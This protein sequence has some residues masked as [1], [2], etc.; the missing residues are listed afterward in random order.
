[1]LPPWKVPAEHLGAYFQPPVPDDEDVDEELEPSEP[2]LDPASGP[3]PEPADSSFRR[4]RS[5]YASAV[6]YADEAVVWLLDELRD[7][8][9]AEETL[10]VVTTDH[11]QALGEHGIIGPYRPW[12][13]DE[14]IH[15]PLTLRLP[16]AAEGGRRI[17]ALAQSTD[18]FPTLLDV[19][20]IAAPPCHGYS[21]SPLA[22]GDVESVRS[23]VCCSLRLGDRED[24][25]LRTLEWGF[26][27]PVAAP[28]DDAP[29]TPQL[30]VKPD[31][32]WEVNNVI[33]HHLE[34]A[35]RFEQTLR[36]F[37]ASP[38]RIGLEMPW[39]AHS[40]GNAT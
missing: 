18:L 31:D 24:W 36:E 9:L 1:L 6:S 5:T 11:G 37:V 14:L 27:L 38:R 17:S 30:Y 32:R 13:H 12:L 8:G 33:Q 4:L 28:P 34:L 19:F 29:R 23:H 10:L 16:R 22:R 15:L 7:R 2:L 20:D 39:T 3:L 25:A 40:G 35:E 21:L 26:L